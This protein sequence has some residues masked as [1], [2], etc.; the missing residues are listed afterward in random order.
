MPDHALKTTE[1][2]I[3]TDRTSNKQTT[4]ETDT[5]SNEGCD[6]WGGSCWLA[7]A[8]GKLGYSDLSYNL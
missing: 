2:N 6:G 4:N 5:S 1:S 3:Y 8:Q 7:T